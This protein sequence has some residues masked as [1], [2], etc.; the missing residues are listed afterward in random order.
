[1][2]KWTPWSNSIDVPFAA[3]QAVH[4]A[5]SGTM[6]S[7]MVGNGEHLF[8]AHT[9]GSVSSGDSF[10]VVGP[11][12]ESFE[13]K[14]LGNFRF[15]FDRTHAKD[16]YDRLMFIANEISN[17]L[18]GTTYS[19]FHERAVSI[20]S[21]Q[22]LGIKKTLGKTYKNGRQQ[23]IGLHQIAK[24]LC[25]DKITRGTHSNIRVVLD[26]VLQVSA[27]DYI[28]MCDIAGFSHN[29]NFAEID[30]VYS[31]LTDECFKNPAIIEEL[32]K[33]IRPSEILLTHADNLAIV[34]KTLGYVILSRD[35]IDR[36]VVFTGFSKGEAQFK[37]TKELK[38]LNVEIVESNTTD[39]QLD[40][41]KWFG[42]NC[43]N[44]Q[45]SSFRCCNWSSV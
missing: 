16:V 31:K 14:T 37:T 2:I 19:K 17:A 39:R 13:V 8:A 36:F 30:E 28:K 20:T 12:G 29:R 15:T 4:Q 24:V 22:Y 42:D 33:S 45:E 23:D 7:K 32:W 10:D 1:L 18:E 38:E 41:T 6:D 27:S 44:K 35:E 5:T 43:E 26:K 40:F 25:F 9:A 34:S 21:T 11:D 3:A